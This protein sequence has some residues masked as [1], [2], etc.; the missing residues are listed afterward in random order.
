[1]TK[2]PVNE[3]KAKQSKKY[4]KDDQIRGVEPIRDLNE[5]ERMKSALKDISYR[6]YM[7]FVFGINTGLRIGDIL[8]LT[9]GDVRGKS[10]IRIREQKT[11]KVRDVY[12]TNGFYKELNEYCKNISDENPLF[13]SR[14][15]KKNPVDSVRFYRVMKRAGEEAGVN[16]HIGTH[17]LRK[18][19]G[20]HMYKKTKDVA[21]IMEMLNHES[22]DVTRKYLGISKDEIKKA[23]DD[24]SL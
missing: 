23:H 18:T 9:A 22:P 15:N 24:F 6:D 2:K 4:Q 13:P 8:A 10:E 17:T 7:I 5:I 20:Y 19:F 1:M 12:I 14:R 16:A 11:G 3:Q 21:M